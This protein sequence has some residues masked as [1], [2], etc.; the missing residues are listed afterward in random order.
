M[1]MLV[2]FG[3]NSSRWH[4]E[5]GCSVCFGQITRVERR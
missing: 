2:C 4:A 3:R 5:N 1:V